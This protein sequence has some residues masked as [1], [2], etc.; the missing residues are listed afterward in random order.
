MF[1]FVAFLI[2]SGALFWAAY[3]AWV[4]PE[5][6]AAEQLAA[7]L[8]GAR[9]AVPAG[10]E[11]GADLIRREQRG[12]LAFLG[13]FV[14]WLGVVRRLQTFILQANLSYRAADVAGLSIGIALLS[15]L[16]FTWFV[17]ILLLQLVLAVGMGAIPIAWIMRVRRR[18][19]SRFEE[20]L[21]D[22]IDLF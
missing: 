15:F 13:D 19:L 17:K 7:R 1:V 12:P 9:I 18:R 11:R 14:V 6:R 20:Q 21:P 4:I 10:R 2:F 8:L 3:Y 5:K 22:A 16:L